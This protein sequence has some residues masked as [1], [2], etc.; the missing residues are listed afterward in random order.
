CLISGPSANIHIAIEDCRISII[1]TKSRS[2]LVIA[3][4]RRTNPAA[5]AVTAE[6]GYT[7]ATGCA[8][9][10]IGRSSDHHRYRLNANHRVSQIKVIVSI[11]SPAI[12]VR[13][14]TALN[15]DIGVPVEP[16]GNIRRGTTRV[17]CSMIAT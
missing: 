14:E 3:S 12:T 5:F 6:H 17:D 13:R 16:V 7:M 8:V 4:V 2:V 1:A 11:A 15:A 9:I 10:V